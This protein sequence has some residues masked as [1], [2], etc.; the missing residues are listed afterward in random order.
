MMSDVLAVQVESAAQAAGLVVGSSEAAEKY[1]GGGT[2]KFTLALVADLAKTQLLE[3]SEG[4]EFG[5]ADLMEGVKSYLAES[6]KRLKNPRPDCYLTLHGLPL[7]FGK[8]GWPFQESNSGDDT[9]LVH[10]AI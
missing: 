9:S 6:A 1:S 2:T 5:R 4:F 8:F 10:G 7:S 3:L